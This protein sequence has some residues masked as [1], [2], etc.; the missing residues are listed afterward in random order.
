MRYYTSK[1]VGRQ[2]ERGIHTKMKVKLAA[3]LLVIAWT[4][5]RKHEAFDPKYLKS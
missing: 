1:L 5:M 3:K 2:G 4:I